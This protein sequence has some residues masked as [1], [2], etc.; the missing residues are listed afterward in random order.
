MAT[1]TRPA[2]LVEH[3]TA[4]AVVRWE[5]S[6]DRSHRTAFER[7]RV[8]GLAK[9]ELVDAGVKTR[10]ADRIK[11]GIAAELDANRTR[12][13]YDRM[14]DLAD[15]P[16]PKLISEPDREA[17]LNRILANYA[18]PRTPSPMTRPDEREADRVEALYSRHLAAISDPDELDDDE[19]DELLA[20]DDFDFG[21]P[22]MVAPGACPSD[23]P[24]DRESRERFAQLAPYSAP[25]GP[26]HEWPHA[27]AD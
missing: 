1:V 24:T 12:L 5:T 6:P 20:D 21:G 18:A 10:E 26:S 2:T 4:R 16:L 27:Y 22:S 19:L 11:R 13:Q 25:H 7:L 14:L 17:M 8:L 15:E 3:V 9:Q 23:A